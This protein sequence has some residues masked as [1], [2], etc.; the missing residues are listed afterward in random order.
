[1]KTRDYT[2]PLEWKTSHPPFELSEW[3]ALEANQLEPEFMSRHFMILGETGSG[4]TK[5]AV[6]PLLKAILE[7]PKPELY[8]SYVQLCE[9]TGEQPDEIRDLHASMLIIDPKLE[10]DDYIHQLDYQM[11]ASEDESQR[12]RDIISLN[13]HSASKTV[14]LF[15]GQN[16]RQKT[17]VGI[18]DQILSISSY[19][20]REKHNT[21]DP[22]WG[23][24]ATAVISAVLAINH[25]IYLN[26]GLDELRKFWQKV[27]Q[28][29]Q[30]LLH[31][32]P[33]GSATNA[34]EFSAHYDRFNASLDNLQLT[35]NKIAQFADDKTIMDACEQINNH[36]ERMINAADDMDRGRSYD[37]ILDCSKDVTVFCQQ[38]IKTTNS[39]F[40]QSLLIEF[41]ALA[42]RTQTLGEILINWKPKTATQGTRSGRQDIHIAYDRDNYLQPIFTLFNI[43]SFLHRDNTAPPRDE[44][45]EAFVAI[46]REYGIQNNDVL[47]MESLIY[48]ADRTYTSIIGVVNNILQ[49]MT[50]PALA[51]FL[52]L[53]PYEAPSPENWLS[54]KSVLDTGDC[55]IYT[56]TDDDELSNLVGRTLKMKFFELSLK[57]RVR[58]RPFAYIC[59][60]FQRYITSDPVSGEQSFLDRCRAYRGICVLAS[61]SLASLRYRLGTESS[62]IGQPTHASLDVLLNNTGNKLFFRNTDTTTQSKLQQLLPA[63]NIKDKLHIVQ[64]RPISTLQPGEC[65]YLMSTGRYG[66]GQIQLPANLNDQAYRHQAYEKA[67]LQFDEI[68]NMFQKELA[69]EDWVFDFRPVRSYQQFWLKGWQK[70]DLWLH[71]E[72]EFTMEDLMQLDNQF[73]MALHIEREDRLQFLNIFDQNYIKYEVIYKDQNF[74]FLPT[75]GRVITLAYKNYPITNDPDLLLEPFQ[76]AL[77]EFLLLRNFIQEVFDKL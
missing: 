75:T 33:S 23:Q 21:R 46:C 34:N 14:W 2:P 39:K 5:S 76:K 13:L 68:Y 74:Q 43:S 35:A 71:F 41:P 26:E 12:I 25:Q 27:S 15:E 59:D 73:G 53:N 54:I 16:I 56:P 6:M 48:L 1:M 72:L 63:S 31:N 64:V 77:Q 10:L 24:Q 58:K 40:E 62:S 4:K 67:Q 37:K 11:R 18:T 70:P 7:Y 28:K 42:K 32:R 65:Y 19:T 66:R 36:V 8:E 3:E 45:L 30:D 9:S 44:A 20:E 57:R 60:E 52:S 38:R 47:R 61:Q 49:E 22:F 55:V 17:A 29:I 69:V 51:G 50:D